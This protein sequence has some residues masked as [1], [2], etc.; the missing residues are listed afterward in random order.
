MPAPDA[1]LADALTARCLRGIS[2][3]EAE[4]QRLAGRVLAA[5]AQGAWRGHLDDPANTRWLERA[6]TAGID[7]DRWLRGVEPT[8]VEHPALGRLVIDLERDPLEILKIGAWFKTCLSPHAMNFYST[9]V[10]AADA[11]KCALVAR[12]ARGDAIARRIVALDRDMRLYAFR[13][14][15]HHSDAA[16]AQAFDGHIAR[17][18]RSC[19]AAMPGLAKVEPLTASAW[20][21]DDSYRAHDTF[22][23]LLEGHETH[24]AALDAL[25]RE[26]GDE[27]MRRNA[28]EWISYFACW[29]D[30]ADASRS[31]AEHEKLRGVYAALLGDADLSELTDDNIDDILHALAHP[32]HRETRARVL[33]ACRGL[34]LSCPE[35]ALAYVQAGDA[36]EALRVLR[37]SRGWM[38][39]RA[40]ALEAL[41]EV[42]LSLRRPRKAIETYARALGGYLDNDERARFEARRSEIVA[43][44]ESR[45]GTRVKSRTIG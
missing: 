7:T 34:E 36:G 4:C 21:D 37:R 18:A 39:E 41:A 27:L 40:V 17:L 29:N 23:R 24:E 35:L 2:E 6:R 32:L 11:N 25:R 19:G 3:V 30:D 22:K 16:I 42:Q 9:I 15:T 45:R 38:A 13:L 44:I 10:V 14:Y 26:C 28:I 5:H 1:W 31:A 12:N 43:Q 20:Y 8:V 33:A